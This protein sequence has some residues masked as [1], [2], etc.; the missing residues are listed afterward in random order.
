MKLRQIMMMPILSDCC[1]MMM[2]L[3]VRP[4][5]ILVIMACSCLSC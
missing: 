2:V 5:I 1:V 3:A 4:M